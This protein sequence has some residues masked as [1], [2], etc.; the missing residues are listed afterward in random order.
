MDA[1]KHATSTEIQISEI[2]VVFFFFF[3]NSLLQDEDV[4]TFFEPELPCESL[5]LARTRSLDPARTSISMIP[6]STNQ[7][8]AHQL[9][10]QRS[11]S[12]L[13]RSN[14]RSAAWRPIVHDR[15]SL[16][17]GSSVLDLKAENFFSCTV[18]RKQSEARYLLQSSD[19]V[20]TLLKELAESKSPN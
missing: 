5:A 10:K 7:V 20:V 13:E 17:E 1:Y 9:R 18:S 8:K 11:L 16:P 12:T 19:D 6:D 4:Y 2:N 15:M 3:W 14:Y